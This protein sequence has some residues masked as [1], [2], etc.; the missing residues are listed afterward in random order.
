MIKFTMAAAVLLTAGLAVAAN[1]PLS[2]AH[3][4]EQ[5]AIATGPGGVLERYRM[6]LEKADMASMD[7]LFAEDSQIF[8]NGKAEGTFA[9]YLE[10]HLGPELGHFKS[11]TFPRYEVELRQMQDV[12]LAT[13]S[14]HY[15]IELTDGR[16]IERDGVATSVLHKRGDDWKILSY[17]SSSRTPPAK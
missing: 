14:Y 7:G 13:E 10:H 16:V 11:F 2:H 6:A 5:A 9:N 12:A 1:P 3:P 4:I 17:H 15:R 8:E